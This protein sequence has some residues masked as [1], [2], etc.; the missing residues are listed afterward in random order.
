MGVGIK[1]VF[2]SSVAND[3]AVEARVQNLDFC[4]A[5]DGAVRITKAHEIS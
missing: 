2:C 3:L 4:P 5:A 1:D